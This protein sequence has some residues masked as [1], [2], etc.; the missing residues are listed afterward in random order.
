MGQESRIY[1]ALIILDIAISKIQMGPGNTGAVGW[2][3]A[4]LEGPLQE[5][6]LTRLDDLANHLPCK[7]TWE[8]DISMSTIDNVVH[9][10][11]FR[12]A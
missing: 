12:L 11:S 4:E 6:L 9:C 1:E 5:S 2:L 7:I 8:L 3:E 10:F